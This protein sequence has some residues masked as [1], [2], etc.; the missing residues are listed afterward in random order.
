[1]EKNLP[2][3]GTQDEKQLDKLY[4]LAM[5]FRSQIL[6]VKYDMLD[7]GFAKRKPIV[8][9]AS[10]SQTETKRTVTLMARL[11]VSQTF[12]LLVPLGA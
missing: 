7:F 6:A 2:P 5:R 9:A 1:M 3:E 11:E 4:E 10:D 8:E 12:A